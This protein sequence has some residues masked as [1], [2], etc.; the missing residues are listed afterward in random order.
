MPRFELYRGHRYQ[1]DA[2]QRDGQWRGSYQVSF[3]PLRQCSL[4][5]TEERALQDAKLAAEIEIDALVRAG[6][7]RG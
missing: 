4:R 5:L 7:G 3:R 6:V 1:Y 2:T